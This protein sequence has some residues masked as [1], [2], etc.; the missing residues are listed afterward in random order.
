[1]IDDVFFIFEEELLVKLDRQPTFEEVMDYM[2]KRLTIT[3]EEEI[4]YLARKI[5]GK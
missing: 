1:M 4:E 2:D 3:K 5:Y